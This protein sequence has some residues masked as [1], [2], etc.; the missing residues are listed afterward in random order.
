MSNKILGLSLTQPW[1]SLMALGAK[2]VE[3]RSWSTPYRGLV[4]IQA[5]KN[6]PKDCQELCDVEVFHKYC[7]NP[8]SL[9]LGKIIAVGR[10]VAVTKTEHY[11][12]YLEKLNAQEEIY[13]GDYSPGRYAWE[14]RDIKALDTPI[15][16][17]G[18]LNLWELSEE[19]QRQL[20]D[21]N[22]GLI[23]L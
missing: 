1:A 4:A 22:N 18:A 10:L 7:P 21:F 12:K 6:F 13:F 9:P 23:K 17:K 3:T 15:E 20:L 16:C 11:I 19:L 2:S 14:F 5:A 8:K